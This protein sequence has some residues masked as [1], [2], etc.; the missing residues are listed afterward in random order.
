MQFKYV[1]FLLD[2]PPSL[3]RFDNSITQNIAFYSNIIEIS[4]KTKSTLVK[5][6]KFTVN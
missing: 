3:G 4:R 1:S 5:C 6:N 2:V